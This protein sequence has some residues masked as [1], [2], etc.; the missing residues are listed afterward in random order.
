MIIFIFS[1]FG[2]SF[3]S[4]VSM[5]SHRLPLNHDVVFKRS[6]CPKCNHNL[7]LIDLIPLFSWLL[8]NGK[9][10]YCDKPISVRY[11]LIEITTSFLFA[12]TVSVIGLNH[13]S[14]LIL[15]VVI[16][17]VTLSVIDFEHYII[18]DS[19]QIILFIL[20]II[21]SYLANYTI[22]YIIISGI[23]GFLSSYGIGALYK[24][25]RHKDGLGFGDVK[26]ILTISIFI[27]YQ[28]LV[29]FYLLSGLFGAVNGLIWQY[30]FKSNLFPFGPSLALSLFLCLI[31][32]LLFGISWSENIDIIEVLIFSNSNYFLK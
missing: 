22:S 9:C 17:L 13:Y 18:P 24:L 20:A 25:V 30:M 31:I 12:F 8:N 23:T 14:Y 19:L 11:P 29:F 6:H 21:W 28:N 27:G 5:L 4:F 16:F 32:P 1:L 7:S 10:R 15:T 26:F 2:L 3:G